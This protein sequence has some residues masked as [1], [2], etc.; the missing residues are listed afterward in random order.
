MLKYAAFIDELCI[1]HVSI[2]SCFLMVSFQ[3]RNLSLRFC[4]LTT[5]YG[6]KFE[7]NKMDRAQEKGVERGSMRR[8]VNDFVACHHYI[9]FRICNL[10]SFLILL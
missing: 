6:I 9:C 5:Y 2:L 3:Q 4:L 8:N 1:V 10:P 7:C